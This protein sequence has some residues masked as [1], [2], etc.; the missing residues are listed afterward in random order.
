MK[1]IKI[2]LN[3]LDD[4]INKSSNLLNGMLKTSARNKKKNNNFWNIIIY[5]YYNYFIL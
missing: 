2:K 1:N 3:D 5:N 4:D